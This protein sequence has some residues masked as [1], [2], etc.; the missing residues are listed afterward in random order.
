MNEKNLFEL[1]GGDDGGLGTKF[2]PILAEEVSEIVNEKD[3]LLLRF[4]EPIEHKD[5]KIEFIVVTPHNPR[6]TLQQMRRHGCEVWIG[7]VRHGK[8]DDVLVNGVNQKNVTYWAIGDCKVKTKL[9]EEQF[10]WKSTDWLWLLKVALTIFILSASENLVWASEKYYY[11]STKPEE[12]TIANLFLFMI[13]T[14]ASIITWS[15]IVSIDRIR[16]KDLRR[17]T[18]TLFVLVTFL[19]FYV[20]MRIHEEISFSVIFLIASIIVYFIGTKLA[21]FVTIKFKHLHLSPLITFFIATLILLIPVF[22]FA[23]IEGIV[24]FSVI[25][26]SII[27]FCHDSILSFILSIIALC[28]W[29]AKD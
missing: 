1:S 29:K 26:I 23:L 15:I 22:K 24:N 16:S 18:S 10:Q 11:L 13:F 25:L 8:E 14:I 5:K 27:I 12:V 20:H 4:F 2:G 21:M 6:Y 9:K 19:S 28:R 3:Y 17:L 7:R